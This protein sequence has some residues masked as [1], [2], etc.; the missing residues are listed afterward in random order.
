MFLFGGTNFGDWNSNC[1]N[2]HLQTFYIEFK[3]Y[4]R[5]S[6][7]IWKWHAFCVR[8]VERDYKI[9]GENGQQVYKVYAKTGSRW[10]IC[11]SLSYPEK[12]NLQH[13][14]PTYPWPGVGG[15]WHWYKLIGKIFL[16]IWKPLA[17]LIHQSILLLKLLLHMTGFWCVRKCIPS[18]SLPVQPYTVWCACLYSCKF[19]ICFIRL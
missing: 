13:E 14:I 8:W 18:W 11:H 16:A 6:P 15:A 7:S 9:L 4:Q 2:F 10:G 12:G 1:Q 17:K 3:W 5:L 19:Q